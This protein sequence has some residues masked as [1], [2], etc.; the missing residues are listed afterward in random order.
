[1]KIELQKNIS[2][3]RNDNCGIFHPVDLTD[4]GRR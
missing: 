3:R 2:C 4:K 1:M